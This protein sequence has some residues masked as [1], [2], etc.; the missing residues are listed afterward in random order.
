LDY[1]LWNLAARQQTAKASHPQS[2]L[3]LDNKIQVNY[4]QWNQGASDKSRNSPTKAAIHQ[5]MQLALS[6]NKKQV[7]H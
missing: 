2:L 5:S 4:Q 7:G 1:R 3:E 6:S